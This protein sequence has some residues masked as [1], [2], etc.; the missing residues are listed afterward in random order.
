MK[1]VRIFL[2]LLA[3]WLLLS[4]PVSAA[5]SASSVQTDVSVLS[6][7]SCTVE[8]TLQ[9]TLEQEGCTFPIPAA[10]TDVLLNGAPAQTQADGEDLLLLLNLGAG[11]HSITIRYRLPCVVTRQEA[12]GVTVLELL[13]GFD[14]PIDQF[15]FRVTLPGNISPAPTF[16]SGY[17]QDN[18]S[19]NLLYTVDGSSL[20]GQTTAGLK[21]HETLTVTLSADWTAFSQMDQHR[22]LLSGWSWAILGTFLLA[23]LYYCITLMPRLTRRTRCFGP[24]DGVTAGELGTCLTACGTDL[25][26]LVISWAQMGYLLIEIDGEDHVVLRKRMDMGNERNQL[27]MRCFQDLFH[28]RTRVDGTGRHFAAIYRKMAS[29][30]ALLRQLYLP[31]SGNPLLFHALATVPALIFGVQLG[32]EA[33]SGAGGVLLALCCSLLLAVLS[34]FIRAGGKC[35][36]L[37][38]K[39]PLLLGVGCGIMWLIPGVLAG[40]TLMSALLLALQ[41]LSGI[42]VAYGGKRSEMGVRCLAQIRG[43]RHHLRKAPANELQQL[44]R[45]NPDYFYEMAPYA[46]ALGLDRRFARRFGKEPLPETSYLDVGDSR[47]MTAREWAAELRYAADI[48][49]KAQLHHRRAGRNMR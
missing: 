49:N 23:A 22:P 28:R 8:L 14:C 10:A 43:M 12:Q 21:D 47:P 17:Y 20:Q 44:M 15:S 30:S 42:A 18:I 6:D 4:I 24:P 46:L 25:T 45:Q 32:L 41:F 33:A 16:T 29:K 37:R 48:L 26:M 3:A 1:K 36:P 2:C 9:L 11:E 39:G 38:N 31:S 5:S 35:L 13:G 34:Y 40:H 19:S 27:E 7:G